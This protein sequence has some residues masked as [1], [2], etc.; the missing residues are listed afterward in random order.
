MLGAQPGSFETGP[1]DALAIIPSGPPITPASAPTNVAA[2]GGK[3]KATVSWA[4][5][6]STGG[7]AIQG[8]Q[9]SSYVAGVFQ[10]VKYFP[11]TATSQVFSP[12]ANGV[13]VQFRVRAVTSTDGTQS[14]PTQAVVPPFGSLTSFVDRMGRDLAF[15]CRVQAAGWSALHPEGEPRPVVVI[16]SD[17][18][19]AWLWTIAPWLGSLRAAMQAAVEAGAG[20]DT[21]R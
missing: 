16:A 7:S 4:A 14:G 9:V 20:R 18:V 3:G 17:P 13:P 6:A 12:L 5:P 10:T 2:V 19:G 11:G 8:Y 21:R 15:L 1:Y